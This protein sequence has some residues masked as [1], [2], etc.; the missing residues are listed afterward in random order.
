VTV[1]AVGENGGSGGRTG[2]AR[3]GNGGGRPGSP[4]LFS[5]ADLVSTP[6]NSFPW[7]MQSK[8]DLEIGTPFDFSRSFQTHPNNRIEL[9]A[10]SFLSWIWNFSP[11]QF[12]AP[13]LCNQT[14]HKKLASK[15]NY[16]WR[17]LMRK[18]CVHAFDNQVL[19]RY[20]S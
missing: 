5:P 9:E 8:Q 18:R 20:I 10:N 14:Q 2:G 16:C 13:I 1:A 3:G 12:H 17:I 7:L 19:E 6:T 4:S 11:I 15:T